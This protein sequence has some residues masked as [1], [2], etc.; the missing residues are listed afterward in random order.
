MQP[1]WVPLLRAGLGVLIMAIGVA[2]LV[3]SR[4]WTAVHLFLLLWVGLGAF[5]VWAS[6]QERSG[7]RFDGETLT[8]VIGRRAHRIAREDVLDLRHD[9]PDGLPWRIEA[10]VTD[11]ARVPLLGVPPAELEAMQAWHRAG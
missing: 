1:S 4:P 6:R 10:I 7:T 2:A 8:V 3:L 9:S 11:G 5:L